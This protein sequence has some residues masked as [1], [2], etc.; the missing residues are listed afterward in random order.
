MRSV[1]SFLAAAF[2]AAAALPA[3]GGEASAQTD[4]MVGSSLPFVSQV[5]IGTR[6]AANPVEQPLCPTDSIH[7]RL[8][9]EFLN[10]CYAIDG[11]TILETNPPSLL[12]SIDDGCYSICGQQPRPWRVDVVFP[13]LPFGTYS[14]SVTYTKNLCP[15]SSGADTTLGTVRYP[16]MVDECSLPSPL[17]PYVNSVAIEPKSGNLLICPSDS[18]RVRLAGVFPDHCYRLEGIGVAESFPPSLNVLVAVACSTYCIQSLKPWDAEV[19]LPPMPAGNYGLGITVSRNVCPDGSRPD[20]VLG[21]AR[22]PFA[23]VDCPY[24]RPC[25]MEGWVQNGI[26]DATV[27]PGRPA[28]VTFTVAPEVPLAGLQG[29]FS[30]Y[31]EGLRITKLEAVGPAAGMHVTWKPRGS[32]AEFVMFAENGAPIPGCSIVGDSAGNRPCPVPVLAVTLE[33]TGTHAPPVT[34]VTASALLGSDV[35]G[36]GV[37]RCP[38]LTLVPIEARVCSAEGGCDINA[39]A[40]LDIRDIVLLAHCLE[41]PDTTQ[42]DL[43]VSCPPDCNQDGE[44]NLDDVLCC[45]RQILLGPP[46]VDCPPDTSAPHP[47]PHVRVALGEI[48]VRDAVVTLP[49]WVEGLG[50]IGGALLSFDYPEDRYQAVVRFAGAGSGWLRLQET[51]GGESRVGLMRFNDGKVGPMSPPDVWPDMA[52]ELTLKPGR[53]HGGRVAVNRAEFSGPAGERLAAN[54]ALPS[55][56]LGSVASIELSEPRPNPSLNGTRISL[57]LS[58]AA[59]AEVQVY[60]LGGRAVATIHRGPLPAGVLE[61]S[62]NGRRDGGGG[63]NAGIYFLRATAAGASAMRKLVVLGR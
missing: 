9:G 43:R 38:I 60:D 52:L 18:I 20:T 51:A 30:L 46:C 12:V 45:A 49:F 56:S 5:E 3:V 40:R 10:T 47:A 6:T 8:S 59:D 29:E 48:V 13:P 54:T 57:T 15:D 50:D 24:P 19:M 63:L 22:F 35:N 32:G 61:L 25:F 41:E 7:V 16:F 33:Q 21:S 14:L 58:V 4:P 23:V 1:F 36:T 34:H 11:V 62:W 31:P 55:V 39:D 42:L 28:T 2:L 17:L 44:R 37:P 27:G 26:C 53:E